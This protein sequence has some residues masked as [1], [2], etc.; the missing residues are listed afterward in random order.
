MLRH[1]SSHDSS[2]IWI[3]GTAV[4]PDDRERR[5]G[6]R[7]VCCQYFVSA[8]T[9]GPRNQQAHEKDAVGLVCRATLW[10]RRNGD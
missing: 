9:D 5:M 1:A 10:R 7:F 3:A 4:C 6:S 8:D 2:H